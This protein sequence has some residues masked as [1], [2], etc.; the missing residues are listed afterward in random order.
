MSEFKTP[1]L[2][3]PKDELTLHTELPIVFIPD[4]HD[5]LGDGHVRLPSDT[6]YNV[7]ILQAYDMLEEH[8]HLERA[9]SE[10]PLVGD[11]RRLDTKLNLLLQLFGELIRDRRQPPCPK[12]LQ[13]DRSGVV[14]CPKELVPASMTGIIEIFVHPSIPLPVR[15][16]ATA[17]E[18]QANNRQRFEF[19]PLNALEADQLER[20]I[21]LAHRQQVADFRRDQR[22]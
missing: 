15:W 14:W 22:R 11:L 6:L 3:E 1:F 8:A 2:G 17:A 5:E 4:T 20:L 21:F 18:P 16:R 12:A 10:N 7:R 19:E 13:L 9:D